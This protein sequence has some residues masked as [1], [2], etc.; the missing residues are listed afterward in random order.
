MN[1]N[2]ILSAVDARKAMALRNI[3]E[4][5]SDPGG[6]LTK[7]ASAGGQTSGGVLQRYQPTSA[8]I[9]AFSQNAAMGTINPTF[10]R[11]A[12][13]RDLHGEAAAKSLV[14]PEVWQSVLQSEQRLSQPTESLQSLLDRQRRIQTGVEGLEGEEKYS[15]LRDIAG[16]IESLNQPATPLP[17]PPSSPPGK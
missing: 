6:L 9:Q 11:L 14:T 12:L 1:I 5:L 8:D 15:A 10:G 3:A 7:L 2:E 13:I 16:K 4:A 17:A